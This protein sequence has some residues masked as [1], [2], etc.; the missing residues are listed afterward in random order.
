MEEEVSMYFLVRTI[1]ILVSIYIWMI[2]IRALLSWTNFYWRIP[3]ANILI[4]LVDPFLWKIRSFLPMPRMAIDIS[5]II[6]IL[7]LEL[8]RYGIEFALL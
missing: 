1:D 4:R 5:P 2:I 7:L 6:A 8:F 3:I